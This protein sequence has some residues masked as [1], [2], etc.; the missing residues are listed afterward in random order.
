VLP[1]PTGLIIFVIGKILEFN[2]S[3]LFEIRVSS[4]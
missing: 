2:S 4:R 3:L 1:I